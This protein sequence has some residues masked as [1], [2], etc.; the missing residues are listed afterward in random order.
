MK[1]LKLNPDSYHGTYKLIGGEVCL[2]FVN[3]ISWP[4]TPKSHDWLNSWSNIAIWASAVGLKV[5]PGLTDDIWLNLNQE[6]AVLNEV[7]GDLKAVLKPMAMNKQLPFAPMEKLDLLVH[8][9][10]IMRYL[11]TETHKWRW[12]EGRTMKELLAPV[13]WNAAYTLTELEPKRLKYCGKCE[14]LFYDKT[15]SATRKWCDMADCGGRNKAL[16]YY[17]RKKED[18]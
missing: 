6:L 9:S 10:F 2:D 12:K 3:T 17:H 7:R 4:G 15:R 1:A 11:D 18:T 14:W 13:I 8:Q 16:K 5:G